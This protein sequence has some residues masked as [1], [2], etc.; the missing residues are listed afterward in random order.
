MSKVMK[1]G[2]MQLWPLIACI[3]LLAA[4][5]A[6]ED[7]RDILPVSDGS[8]AFEVEVPTVR[9]IITTTSSIKEFGVFCYAT[10]ANLWA[11]V[12]S[13]LPEKMNNRIVGRIGEKWSYASS[14]Q[15]D[16]E[17]GHYYTFLGYSPYARGIYNA[18]SN[19]L[20]NNI[21]VQ[22]K[23]GNQPLPGAQ[24]IDYEVNG[25]VGEQIDLLYSRN[26]VNITRPVGD[27]VPMKFTHALTKIGF[28]V[29]CHPADMTLESITLSNM[30]YKGSLNLMEG[31]W[32]LKM[33]KKSFTL[34]LPSLPI[35]QDGAAPTDATGTDNN[36]FMIPQDL[37]ASTTTLITLIAK[38][39]A[40]KTITKSAPIAR[41]LE[42]GNGYIYTVDFAGEETA[43]LEVV[44]VQLV[45]WEY[46]ANVNLETGKKF[47]LTY[48]ANGG[49]TSSVPQPEVR[50]YGSFKEPS[51]TVPTWD[52]DHIFLGWNT[53]TDGTGINYTATD[54]LRMPEND[55]TLYAKWG[56]YHTLTYEANAAG[57]TVTDVPAQQTRV[58][59]MTELQLPVTPPICTGYDFIEW[60]TLANGKG[61][62]YQ[63]DASFIMPD[64]DITLYA[65][66]QGAIMVSYD[67]DYEDID[68][69][70]IE[71]YEYYKTGA[72]ITLLTPASRP[73]YTFKHWKR[74]ESVTINPDDP[75]DMTIVFDT[76]PYTTGSSYTV[77]KN[78][79]FQAE[80]QEDIIP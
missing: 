29:F 63:P 55:L 4:C 38:N 10:E 2:Y 57:E 15:W 41:N 62:A 64:A 54:K 8:M 44:D 72:N 61:V 69:N 22:T 67:M 17:P 42:I 35:S 19:P 58:A 75:T 45:P 56:G 33:G 24:V 51:A 18:T 78:E 73:G 65:I 43:Q 48:D 37:T 9:G 53:A 14:A 50:V 68:G 27:I 36:F 23:S 20:G 79:S 39:R 71:K 52:A 6:E 46:D 77:T 28:K 11:D 70:L 59:A 21:T 7:G 66:W 76:T 34:T 49:N 12:T 25:N 80:W 1:K 26:N 40:G 30:P 47:T 60:N 3:S 31:T 32:A 74:V 13:P 16:E 5:A